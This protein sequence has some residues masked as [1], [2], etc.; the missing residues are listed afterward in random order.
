MCSELTGG[1]LDFCG[2]YRF[3]LDRL[4]DI[5]R[6]DATELAYVLAGLAMAFIVINA[7]VMTTAM[8]TWFER[9]ALA[10]FQVRL[11]PNRWGP[12]GTLQPFADLIKLMTKEDT[13]PE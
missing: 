5:G 7:I 10:R 4:N 3:F 12:F 8:Y 1:I 13:V 6:S 11:G 2:I 9:R